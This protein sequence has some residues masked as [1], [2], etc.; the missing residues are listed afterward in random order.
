MVIMKKKRRES[1][2]KQK[3]RT[4]ATTKSQQ[5]LQKQSTGK[6]GV[7]NKN[8]DWICKDKETD[9]N[10]EEENKIY[11]GSLLQPLNV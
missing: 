5:R 11:N 10:K 9:E 7:D 4:T 3:K 2:R 1:N 6:V 8:G